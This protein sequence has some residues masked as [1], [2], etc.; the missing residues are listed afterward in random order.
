MPKERTLVSVALALFGYV[1]LIRGAWQLVIVITIG[2]ISMLALLMLLRHHFPPPIERFL[3]KLSEELDLSILALG[4]SSFGAGINFIH[5]TQFSFLIFL[6]GLIFLF[7]GVFLIFG[8]FGLYPRKIRGY[9]VA[10]L[11]L[12]TISLM[13]FIILTIVS[14][15][16]ILEEPKTNSLIPF[17]FLV[18]SIVLFY[19][20]FK[21]FHES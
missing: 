20:A 16:S 7:S 12:A 9:P 18:Y 15:A 17:L 19:Q 3:N 8:S 2:F 6:E 1:F 13:V 10:S 11:V 14:W 4:L 5:N 21:G